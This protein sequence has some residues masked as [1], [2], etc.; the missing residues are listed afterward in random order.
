[1]SKR[2]LRGI[3]WD[4]DRGF[5]CL[6][7]TAGQFM[8]EH[9]DIEVRWDKRSLRDFGEAPIDILADRYDL[10]IFDHPFSGRARATGSLID[11]APYLPDAEV[12]A[13]MDDSVGPSTRSYHYDGGIYGL[14]TDAAA[15]VAA[16]RPDLLAALR[17]EI[18]QTWDDVLQLA[19]TARLAGKTIVTPACP[20]DAACLLLTMAANLGFPL[21]EDDPHFIDRPAL[22]EV[23]GRLGDLIAASD[24]RS[25]DWNPIQ[26]YDAMSSTDD[27]VYSS[28]AFGYSNYA[29]RGRDRLVRAANI[30]GPGADPRAGALLGGAGYAVTRTCKDIDAAILYGRWL[31]QPSFQRGAYFQAGGQP[32]LRSAWT[33]PDVNRQSSNFFHDTL[34]TMEK[35]YLRPRWNGFLVFFEEMGKLTNHWLRGGMTRVDLI[36]RLHVLY[37]QVR[38][39]FT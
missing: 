4:H 21:G 29:R 23:L 10:V 19:E 37:G 22:D 17:A 7:R 27:I 38:S 12:K 34:E 26:G 3:A 30:A 16:Y 2:T 6:A 33:D 39:D 8:A 14:P 13:M 5:T 20:I 32:G 35:S 24:L 1:M 36:D 25:V 28:L 11:L 9:P 15:H 31:H 18:P